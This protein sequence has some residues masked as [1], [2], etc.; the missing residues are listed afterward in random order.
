[1]LRAIMR[2][3]RRVLAGMWRGVA[4]VAASLFGGAGA[5]AAPSPGP[6]EAIDEEVAELRQ[7][8]ESSPEAEPDPVPVT[9]LGARIHAYAAADADG[10][11]GFDFD[12]VPDDVALALVSLT[13]VQLAR[14]AAAGPVV[15]GRWA[16]GE[17]TGLVGVPLPTRQ[18]RDEGEAPAETAGSE[19][20]P[21]PAALAA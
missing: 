9:S 8:L 21:T 18:A 14:L 5:P 7:K 10:R 2:I 19:P 6:E 3:I 17:R 4:R 1:M 11:A 12:G 15:C 13:E 16:R 20:A